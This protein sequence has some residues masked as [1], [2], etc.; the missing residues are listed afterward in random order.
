MIYPEGLHLD[1]Y[2]VMKQEVESRKA[3]EEHEKR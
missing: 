2:A 3:R 1:T